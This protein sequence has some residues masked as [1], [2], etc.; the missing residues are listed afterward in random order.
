MLQGGCHQ[1]NVIVFPLPSE[2]AVFVL[3]PARGCSTYLSV[4]LFCDIKMNGLKII[5]Y[6]SSA[7]LILLSTISVRIQTCLYL[8]YTGERHRPKIPD[9]P[10]FLTKLRRGSP[11]NATTRSIPWDGR[12]AACGPPHCRS[13]ENAEVGVLEFGLAGEFQSFSSHPWRRSFQTPPEN[14][15][16]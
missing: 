2:S 3:G 7:L 13:T 14:K 4:A 15:R 6:F 10:N 16:R 9:A 8:L 12:K 5:S 11:N 1:Q